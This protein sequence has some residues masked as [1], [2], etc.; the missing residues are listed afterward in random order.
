VPAERQTRACSCRCGTSP[1]RHRWDLFVR[2]RRDP[3]R[4]PGLP[5]S[6]KDTANRA[7][8][9][10]YVTGCSLAC[11]QRDRGLPRYY[12]RGLLPGGSAM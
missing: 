5:A 4:A 8:S 3:L 2:V 9:P 11:T 6:S 1:S 7:S 10:R 12:P